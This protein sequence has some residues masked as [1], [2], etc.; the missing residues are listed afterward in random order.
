MF[1]RYGIRQASLPYAH[2]AYRKHSIVMLVCY[3]SDEYI[4]HGGQF[5]IITHYLI[6]VEN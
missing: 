3:G 2:L 6:P 5:F 1:T 4:V